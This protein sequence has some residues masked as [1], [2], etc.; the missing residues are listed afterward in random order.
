M[1]ETCTSGNRLT[2]LAMLLA[3]EVMLEADVLRS[4]V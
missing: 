4:P 1:K 2:R 3:A